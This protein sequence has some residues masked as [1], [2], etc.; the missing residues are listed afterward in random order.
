M[1]VK[2]SEIKTNKLFD[3]IGMYKTQKSED[4]TKI[5]GHPIETIVILDIKRI[6]TDIKYLSLCIS[7]KGINI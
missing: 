5:K 2:I 4:K 1:Y 3:N 7:V 6:I